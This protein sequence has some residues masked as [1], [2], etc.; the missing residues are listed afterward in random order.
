MVVEAGG[1]AEAGVCQ[2]PPKVWQGSAGIVARLD[3]FDWLRA[4]PHP[5]P[6]DGVAVRI[7]ALETTEKTGSVAAMCDGKLLL[8]IELNRQ[9][10]SAQSLAPGLQALLRQ[11]QWRPR[12]I[13]LVAVCIGPGSFT[14]LRVGVAA[15]K[16]F[17]YAAN[18]EV[19]GV[20][21]LEVIAARAPGQIQSISVAVDAQRGDVVAQSFRRN[22]AGRLCPEAAARLLDIDTWLAA[23]QPDTVV[24]GPVLQK[25]AGR[26][27]EHVMVLERQYREPRAAALAQL[28]A[29]DYAAGRRDDIWSLSPHYCR[30]SAAEEKAEG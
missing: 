16:A 9:Q 6:G 28:A 11:L 24:S 1:Q 15:A 3:F 30:R 23:I 22:D 10:R 18:A 27:P 25:L 26:V 14:G 29:R 17:A 7:L 19:L 4:E 21:T 8:E 20:G 5:T 13:D 12:D 2:P